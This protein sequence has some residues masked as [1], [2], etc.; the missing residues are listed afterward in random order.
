MLAG[1]LL[2][3][4]FLLANFVLVNFISDYTDN[5]QPFNTIRFCTSFDLIQIAIIPNKQDFD[6][7]L[8]GKE[9][10]AFQ[11]LITILV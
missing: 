3:Y 11:S 7:M 1:D 2:C 10:F 8:A 9:A 4:F 6:K 5:S